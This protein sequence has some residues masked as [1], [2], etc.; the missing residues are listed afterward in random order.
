MWLCW[1]IIWFWPES[2]NNDQNSV[3]KEINNYRISMLLYGKILRS[4]NRLA[5]FMYH[6]GSVFIFAAPGLQ[7]FFRAACETVLFTRRLPRS[8]CDQWRKLRFLLTD[9]WE[10]QSSATG[11]GSLG[12]VVER[13]LC[14]Q[15]QWE[16]FICQRALELT[17]RSVSV[18]SCGACGWRHPQNHQ[19]HSM[20]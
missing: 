11:Q 7:L 15:T 10:G 1:C 2:I 18:W 17:A 20:S 12:N 9:S 4:L 19:S 6:P 3:V 5:P 13:R 8:S 14:L 16:D